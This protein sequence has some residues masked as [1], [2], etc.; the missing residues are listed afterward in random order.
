MPQ[1][2]NL[3]SPITQAPVQSFTARSML[4]ALLVVLLIGAAL[5]GVLAWN[6]ART[7]AS[8]QLG[9][10]DQANDLQK[11]KAAL[12]LTKAN[13]GP[14][15]ASL[16]QQ[17]QARQSELQMRE[18]LL[19]AVREGAVQTGSAHS[20]RLKL[21]AQSIPPQVWV[22]GLKADTRRFEI[23]GYTI[24]PAALNLWVRRLAQS[25]LMR[26]LD[27]SSVRVDNATAGVAGAAGASATDADFKSLAG[28]PVWSFVLVS[29]QHDGASETAPAQAGVRP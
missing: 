8:Y 19:T 13:S 11:M 26:G 10:S 22:T 24:E 2:I 12:D 17:F 18:A 4:R 21:V 15:E 1:Q 28:R 5:G 29:A 20:D 25:P 23:N 9:L 16:Q 27:L 7:S 14:A 6:M 3:C